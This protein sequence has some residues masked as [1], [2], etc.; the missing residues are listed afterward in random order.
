MEEV[1]VVEAVDRYRRSTRRLAC[2]SLLAVLDG[3]HRL[4]VSWSDSVAS[5]DTRRS[6][7]S[8]VGSRSALLRR[9][10]CSGV[11]GRRKTNLGDTLMGMGRF[12]PW[13]ISGKI[14]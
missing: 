7:V 2:L 14:G 6:R 1:S 8:V 11:T 5:K 9:P 12:S 13:G 4:R 3:C 10:C